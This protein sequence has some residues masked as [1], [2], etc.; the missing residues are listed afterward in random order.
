[1]KTKLKEWIRDY[2]NEAG[3][4]KG[5]ELITKLPEEFFGKDIDI[6]QVIDECVEDEMIME[7]EYVVPRAT[8][9]TKTLYFPIGSEITVK[10]VRQ[11]M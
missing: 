3:P 5:T 8:Y 6:V 1:M 9:R 4:I 10:D 7:V 2:V 11:I